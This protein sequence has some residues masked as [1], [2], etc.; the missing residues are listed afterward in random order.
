MYNQPCS[1]GQNVERVKKQNLQKSNA[2][3]DGQVVKTIKIRI[4]NEISC[5]SI[6]LEIIEDE[7]ENHLR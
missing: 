5:K 7:K 4:I 3:I 6:E 2:E 1:I